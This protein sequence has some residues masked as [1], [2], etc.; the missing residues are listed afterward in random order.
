MDSGSGLC[1]T[2]NKGCTQIWIMYLKGPKEFPLGSLPFLIVGGN[3]ALEL[4]LAKERLNL[5]LKTIDLI[6]WTP[7]ML[8]LL[9]VLLVPFLPLRRS[10]RMLL[11][12]KKPI[13]KEYCVNLTSVSG[14][15][16]TACGM[17][18]WVSD[19]ETVHCRLESPVNGK[20][21]LGRQRKMS[22]FNSIKG[23]SILIFSS[24]IKTPP[25]P[26]PS[27]SSHYVSAYLEIFPWY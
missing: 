20:E 12:R 18:A 17:A 8:Y 21:N 25:H 1:T 27:L 24:Y 19:A 16:S 14:F 4:R 11:L 9:L 6:L 10:P 15:L 5:P 22:L 26:P 2:H 13:Y 3:G 23:N 7:Q